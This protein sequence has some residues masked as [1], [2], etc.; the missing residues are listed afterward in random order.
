MLFL[1]DAWRYFYENN[2]NTNCSRNLFYFRSVSKNGVKRRYKYKNTKNGHIWT[3]LIPRCAYHRRVKLCRVHPTAESSSVVWSQTAHHGVKI[4]IFVSLWLLSKGQSREILLG[5][6]TSIMNE[7]I[8]RTFVWFA[9]PN[10]LTPGCHAHREVEFFKLCDQ[11]SQQNWNQTQKNV[12]LFI[13]GP[14]GFAS[15]KKLEV[16]NLLTHSL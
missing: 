16:E 5:V 10:M 12:N 14:V 15:W 9:K 2:T 1:C 3:S 13:R 8:W 6:N 4:E 11:I 7:R